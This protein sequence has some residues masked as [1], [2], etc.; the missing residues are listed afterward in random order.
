MTD[1]TSPD[2]GAA[3]KAGAPIDASH[4]GRSGAIAAILR[5]H[6]RAQY[7][8]IVDGTERRFVDSQFNGRP[9]VVDRLRNSRFF[10]CGDAT[11]VEARERR[12]Q[13]G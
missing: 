4:A 1:R 9:C 10:G 13:A 2:V 7:Q 8:R 5:A 3:S 11:A 6:G 12:T